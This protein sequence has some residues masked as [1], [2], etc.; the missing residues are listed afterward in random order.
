[1]CHASGSQKSS[2]KRFS[3]KISKIIRRKMFCTVSWGRE[4]AFTPPSTEERTMTM[5]IHS[6]PVSLHI[7]N[8]HEYALRKFGPS[9]PAYTKAAGDW[10]TNDSEPK[11]PHIQD[12]RDLKF[13]TFGSPIRA[14]SLGTKELHMQLKGEIKY[15]IGPDFV[16]LYDDPI[17]DSETGEL[18]VSDFNNRLLGRKPND[19]TEE[20]WVHLKRYA[21]PLFL[22]DLELW[23][24][25]SGMRIPV[26]EATRT[27]ID[28]DFTA[29]APQSRTD[30][31]TAAR[32]YSSSFF[33]G[34]NGNDGFLGNLSYAIGL[35][36]LTIQQ[37]LTLP[38]ARANTVAD[39]VI[40]VATVHVGARSV[41]FCD[42]KFD[43]ALDGK[44]LYA[45]AD[46]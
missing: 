44:I 33:N 30:I 2:S 32:W 26:R 6:K 29:N 41:G 38:L 45:N 24:T 40:P 13:R 5:Q 19:F 16:P 17:Y 23:S 46:N 18:D 9:S 8:T 22:V 14:G 10:T 4:F 37:P 42:L 31:L 28:S 11:K 1:M 25:A 20:Q 15:N 36:T 39:M 12:A 21:E 34:E 35:R 7:E 43:F 3:Q 27:E